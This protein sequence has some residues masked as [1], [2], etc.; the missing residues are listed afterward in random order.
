M[1]TGE[2]SAAIAAGQVALSVPELSTPA[3]ATEPES[4]PSEEPIQDASPTPAPAPAP[5]PQPEFVF[6]SVVRQLEAELESTKQALK[7]LES[8]QAETLEPKDRQVKSAL[9]ELQAII[10]AEQTEADRKN[11]IAQLKGLIKAKEGELQK[12]KAAE[13]QSRRDADAALK[14][15]EDVLHQYNAAVQNAKLQVLAEKVINA[16]EEA[17]R[18]SEI[19]KHYRAFDIE[20]LQRTVSRSPF[21]PVTV[22]KLDL[23]TPP[24]FYKSTNNRYHL[25]TE[26]PGPGWELV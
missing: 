13:R 18:N 6:S 25:L 17:Y 2:L 1:K 23:K 16:A 19:R 15:L 22:G 5:T 26:C 21:A 12:L 4:I 9:A 14:K 11:R 3:P 20:P 10:Q 7:L 8:G 24:M